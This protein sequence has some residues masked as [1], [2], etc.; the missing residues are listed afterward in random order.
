MTTLQKEG[1]FSRPARALGRSDSIN[2]RGNPQSAEGVRNSRPIESFM[3]N[4][5]G[6]FSPVYEGR[7]PSQ[8][9]LPRSAV[10]ELARLILAID[11]FM[12]S[13]G[14]MFGASTEMNPG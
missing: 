10:G 11:R 13:R 9:L 2:L 8:R 4:Y 3:T 6:Q 14:S 7:R 1:F 12:A 5:P